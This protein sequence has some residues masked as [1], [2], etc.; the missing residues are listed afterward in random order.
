MAA[1]PSINDVEDLHRRISPSKQA[2]EVIHSHCVVIASLAEILAHHSNVLLARQLD[3]PESQWEQ[4]FSPSG[5]VDVHADYAKVM[6]GRVPR[7]F[8]N[9]QLAYLGGLLHDIGTYMLLKDDGSNGSSLQFDGSRYIL[10]GSI[11]YNLALREGYDESIAG[12]CRNHTG[13]GL[14]REDVINQQL[15]LAVEDYLPVSLEQEVVM[16][17]DKYNSKSVP[18]DFL[19]AEAYARKAARFGEDNKLRWL[20]YVEQYGKPQIELLAKH[21]HM[22]VRQ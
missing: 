9:Q 16:V 1:T 18:P 11:G 21:F 19:T 12:F 8:I 10:H 6:G 13:V 7:R 4:E 20:A 2:Y 15:P 3:L 5:L 17:A 14:T 22:R